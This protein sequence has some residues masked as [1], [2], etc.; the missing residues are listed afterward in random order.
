FSK[1]LAL[2]PRERYADAGV[3]WNELLAAARISSG[4]VQEVRLPRDARAEPGGGTRVERVDVARRPSGRAPS[5]PMQAPVPDVPLHPEQETQALISGA[6]PELRMHAP[7]PAPF[8]PTVS[9]SFE[10]PDLD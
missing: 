1:A 2:D 10:V 4:E 6:A 9:G 7:S 5:G 3:F 8:P